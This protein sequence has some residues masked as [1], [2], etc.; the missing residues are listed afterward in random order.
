MSLTGGIKYQVLLFHSLITT[1]SVISVSVGS[2]KVVLKVIYSIQFAP[3]PH[4]M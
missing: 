2:D 3:K 4:K 1:H